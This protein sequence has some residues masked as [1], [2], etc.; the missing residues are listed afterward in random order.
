MDKHKDWTQEE[1]DMHQAHDYMI[2]NYV[3]K[4]T[5]KW[6]NIQKKKI[7]ALDDFCAE[8]R[9]EIDDWYRSFPTDHSSIKKILKKKKS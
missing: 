9:K 6:E 8:G 3:Y 2:V 5:R 7:K 4:I 1:I